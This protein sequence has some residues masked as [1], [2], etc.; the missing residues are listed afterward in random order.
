MVTEGAIRA[1]RAYVFR[2]PR[3]SPPPST[4]SYRPGAKIPRHRRAVYSAM[5]CPN[6]TN[7]KIGLQFGNI[8]KHR[9]RI[10]GPPRGSLALGRIFDIRGVGPVT[11]VHG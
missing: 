4:G 8:P 5:A 2:W 7:L 1:M 10:P 9:R 3:Y 6:A 11:F